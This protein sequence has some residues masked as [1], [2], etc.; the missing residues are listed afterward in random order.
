MSLIFG[1]CPVQR[2]EDPVATHHNARDTV[3]RQGHAGP[4]TL[5]VKL[6][7][8]LRARDRMQR[9]DYPAFKTLKSICRFDVDPWTD[10]PPHRR[11]F[12]AMKHNDAD[13]FFGELS[14]F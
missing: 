9:H 4:S 6:S 11:H 12:I 1:H 2:F 10:H 8:S 7:Y 5:G 3:P 14:R 13:I